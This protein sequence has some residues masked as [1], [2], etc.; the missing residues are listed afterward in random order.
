MGL[1]ALKLS[2]GGALQDDLVEKYKQSVLMMSQA[3]KKKMKAS[4]YIAK[5]QCKLIR[6]MI[7]R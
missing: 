2:Q 7:M 4:E 6:V 3:S 5:H 1:D